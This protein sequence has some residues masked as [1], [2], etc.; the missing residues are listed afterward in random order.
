MRTYSY[1]TFPT[2]LAALD[3]HPVRLE[4]RCA[5]AP[6]S[7]LSSLTA[8]RDGRAPTM[9]TTPHREARSPSG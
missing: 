3:V 1:T 5:F 8:Q 6:G 4:G 9:P 2:S 7:H